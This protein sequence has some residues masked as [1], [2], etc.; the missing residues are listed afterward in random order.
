MRSNCINTVSDRPVCRLRSDWLGWVGVLPIGNYTILYYTILYY[1]IT[2]AV[3]KQYDLLMMS[4]ELLETCR[5][6]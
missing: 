1:T 2:D 6:L 4:T 5:G 3:L